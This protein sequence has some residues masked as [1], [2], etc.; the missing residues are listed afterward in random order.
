MRT[1]VTLTGASG[2]GK[3]TLCKALLPEINAVE[4]ISYTTRQPRIGEEDGE[5]YHFVTD[6]EFN[7]LT[8]IEETEYAGNRYCL[9]EDALQAIPENG[10][11]ILVVDQH[12]VSCLHNYC[13]SHPDKYRL[14]PFFLCV[15]ERVSK[16][17]MLARGDS[18]KSV[19][20]RLKQHEERQEYCPQNAGLYSR[21]LCSDTYTDLQNNIGIIK[22]FL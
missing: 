9:A 14:L 5:T 12:G 4:I 19:A 1:I 17:R 3:T 13:T 18:A 11:G 7:D 20:V 15:E 10:I 16:E 6:A 21:V 2:S 22:E 8:R